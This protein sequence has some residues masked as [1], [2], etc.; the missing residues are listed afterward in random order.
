[1][2][3]RMIRFYPLEKSLEAIE[4]DLIRGEKLHKS[5]A[6][7][8]LFEKKMIS[9]LKVAEETNQSEFIFNKLYDSYSVELKH[10]GQIMTNVFNF[11]LTLFVGIIVG[12]ILVAMYLPM[13]KLSSVIG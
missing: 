13:F 2:V 5:F 1:M 11:L 4:S 9:L 3:R 10:K 7:H 6:K 8:T 12:V